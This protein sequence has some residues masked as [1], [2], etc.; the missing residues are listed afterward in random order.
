[1]CHH[2]HLWAVLSTFLAY[3]AYMPTSLC[4]HDL[5]IMCHCHCCW[6]HCH[7]HHHDHWCCLCTAVPVGALITETLYLVNILLVYAHE[8][9][10]Q[11]DVNI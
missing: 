7:C 6:H 11:Y 5:S 3:L 9:L 10:G 8:I 1:M 2:H 4:N